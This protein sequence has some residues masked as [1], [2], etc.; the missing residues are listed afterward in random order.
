MDQPILGVLPNN[1]IGVDVGIKS[2]AVTSD[3]E[4]FENPK[5]LKAAEKKLRQ[6]S[7]SVSRKVKGSNNRKKAAAKLARQ[8][9]RVS[10]IRKDTIHKATSAITKQ[11]R[12]VVIESLNISGMMKNRKL[13]KAMADAGL[14][15]FH[16]QLTYKVGRSGGQLIRAD[17]FFPS[18]KT[19]SKCGQ[20]NQAL[21]LSDRVFRCPSCDFTIDRDLNAALN[22]KKLT[23]SY[24]V[25]AC[26]PGSSGWIPEEPTKLPVGQAP[27]CMYPTSTGGINA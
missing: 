12:V 15:E 17:R 9:Y 14:G 8:H 23:G 26:C 11:A 25:S 6:L 20:V 4:V 10:N 2:L 27:N 3:G 22:L 5:A 13:S 1:V 24:P 7:K 18:S 19:C 16:R 21:T